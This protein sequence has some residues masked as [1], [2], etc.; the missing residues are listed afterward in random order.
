MSRP[1]KNCLSTANS[2]GSSGN[3]QK[4]ARTGGV[5]RSDALAKRVYYKQINRSVRVACLGEAATNPIRQ[6]CIASANGDARSIGNAIPN[7]WF[8]RICTP[9]IMISVERMERGE[10]R[11]VSTPRTSNDQANKR[12]LHPAINE[13]FIRIADE[14]S[15]ICT[16]HWDLEKL[17]L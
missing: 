9:L 15:S 17:E 6:E 4:S 13:L 16:N 10:L 14:S 3:S 11:F 1:T 8:L 7:V 5:P 12:D 2:S